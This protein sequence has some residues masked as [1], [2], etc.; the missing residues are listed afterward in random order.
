MCAAISQTVIKGQDSSTMTTELTN[1]TATGDTDVEDVSVPKASA[2][3][4][5]GTSSHSR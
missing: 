4:H 3:Q 5:T 2:S 1:M